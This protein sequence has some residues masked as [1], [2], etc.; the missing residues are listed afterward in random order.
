MTMNC[1]MA[2]ATAHMFVKKA[3]EMHDAIYLRKGDL[4]IEKL[5]ELVRMATELNRSVVS[6][7]MK[8][9]DGDSA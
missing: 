2:Q 7:K 6:W 1:H 5:D 3:Q 9:D 8:F 4:A